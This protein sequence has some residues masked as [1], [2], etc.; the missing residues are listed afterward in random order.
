MVFCVGLNFFP[1]KIEAEPSQQ[2]YFSSAGWQ[3]FQKGLSEKFRQALLFFS[4][5]IKRF[6]PF[7]LFPDFD[8]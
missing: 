4:F 7:E 5:F 3:R 1:G 2:C 8:F 6:E